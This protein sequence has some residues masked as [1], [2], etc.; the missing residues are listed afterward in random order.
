MSKC[1]ESKI[2]FLNKNTYHDGWTNPDH[3]GFKS[4]KIY[5]TGWQSQNPRWFQPSWILIFYWKIFEF[6]SIFPLCTFRLLLTS[7]DDAFFKLA[8]LDHSQQKSPFYWQ[9]TPNILNFI[10]KIYCNFSIYTRHIYQ[11]LF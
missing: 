1:R 10:M 8:T 2:N 5:S 4:L 11:I 3:F 9:K 7:R 6:W